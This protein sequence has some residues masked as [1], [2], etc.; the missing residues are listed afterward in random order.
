MVRAER[1][2]DKFNGP[3]AIKNNDASK[4]PK[5]WIDNDTISMDIINASE[6]VG[7]CYLPLMLEGSTRTW[8]NNLP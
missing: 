8:I 7:T 5:T 2:P 1:Y 6:L 3:C 4:G